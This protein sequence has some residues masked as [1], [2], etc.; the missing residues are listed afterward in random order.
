MFILIWMVIA[1]LSLIVNTTIGPLL[2]KLGLPTLPS[3][4][5]KAG[6]ITLV[7]TYLAMPWARKLLAGWLDR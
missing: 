7:M 1:P 6:L 2:V 5:L 3:T 4:Y